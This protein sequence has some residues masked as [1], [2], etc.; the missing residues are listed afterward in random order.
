MNTV[1]DNEINTIIKKQYLNLL[2]I[3]SNVEYG[4]VDDIKDT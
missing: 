4:N 3:M 2:S 1:K